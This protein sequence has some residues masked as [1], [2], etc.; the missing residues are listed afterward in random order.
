VLGCAALG[1]AARAEPPP[2]PRD[3]S[4]ETQAP[5]ER[6]APGEP[7]ASPES[8]PQSPEQTEPP[9]AA[10]PAVQAAEP[11]AAPAPPTV[12]IRTEPVPREVE[13]TYRSKIVLADVAA[14]AMGSFGGRGAWAA[15]ASLL[16]FVAAAPLVHVAEGNSSSARKSLAFRLIPVAVVGGLSLLL[17]NTSGC[18][19]NAED[20]CFGV[21]ILA[22]LAGL[23]GVV[24]A[25]AN[26]WTWL[27]R[28]TTVATDAIGEPEPR[29]L[30]FGVVAGVNTIDRPVNYSE[31]RE[32]A[33]A[34]A[35]IRPLPHVAVRAEL[36]WARRWAEAFWGDTI[37]DVELAYLQMPVLAQLEV[38]PIGSLR[39][40]GSLGAQAELL[41]GTGGD[42]TIR[43]AGQ[44]WG[45]SAL[46]GG[47]LMTVIGPGHVLS[48]DVRASSRLGSA[49]SMDG[50]TL[51]PDVVT[52]LIGLQY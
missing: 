50:M 29:A 18:R 22:G 7:D 27:P 1:S 45:A 16:T 40:V 49:L 4:E 28:R 30:T 6:E 5:E 11:V 42:R 26:D 8:D 38:G 34:V 19:E 41:L 3:T 2:L 33:G 20:G 43:D 14:I 31:A 17:V 13:V 10:E 36:E 48:F 15:A 35:T 9:P 32:V 12:D 44:T 51:E 25:V 46:Y 37:V 52:A 47:G 23:V 24:T 39:L 21:A